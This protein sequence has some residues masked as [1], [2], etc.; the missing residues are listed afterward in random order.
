[1]SHYKT[2]DVPNNATAQEIRAAYRKKAL[3]VHP[4]KC[5]GS[6]TSFIA[7]QKAYD[8]LSDAQKR[9]AYDASLSGDK[10]GLRKD[11]KPRGAAFRRPPPLS[12]VVAPA[13]MTLAD[14]TAYQFETAPSVLHSGVAHG[15]L[16]GYEGETGTFV[17]LAGDGWWWWCKSGMKYP[18]KLCDP[19][20]SMTRSGIQVLSRG[21][22]STTRMTTT[23]PAV[24]LATAGAKKTVK[25]EEE[26]RGAQKAALEK[27]RQAIIRQG[28]ERVRSEAKDALIAE[29]Q[30]LR[31]SRE[32]F[33]FEA[34]YLIHGTHSGLKLRLSAGAAPTVGEW[35]EM[36]E[37][38][39][40]PIPPFYPNERHGKA[41]RYS[42]PMT[43]KSSDS[44]ATRKAITASPSTSAAPA[45]RKRVTP[46]SGKRS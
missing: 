22:H 12:Q 46:G 30:R 32:D 16:V 43:N 15:D 38:A 36:M 21:G 35:N 33:F 3:E 13:V 9:A 27:M 8:T 28:R 26:E 11:V 20:S 19:A 10:S 42:D 7:L 24:K 18:S 4:D 6:D 44:K 40:K 1:M 29:E 5:N 14:D 45:T 34:L 23:K 39:K 41:S 25:S 31:A 37:S 2:L 17:G